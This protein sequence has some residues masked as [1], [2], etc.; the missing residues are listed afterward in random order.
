M[1]YEFTV[2]TG[3]YEVY[4]GA[5]MITDGWSAGIGGAKGVFNF[6]DYHASSGI[7]VDCIEVNIVS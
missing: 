3:E 6:Y 2:P 7:H 1:S 4:A 5:I